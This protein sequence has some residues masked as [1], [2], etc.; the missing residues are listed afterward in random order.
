[1]VAISL[2][3]QFF[4]YFLIAPFNFLKNKIFLYSIIIQK[5]ID[6][7]RNKVYIYTVCIYSIID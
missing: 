3:P 5:E 4:N 1:M 7:R 2:R 6:V